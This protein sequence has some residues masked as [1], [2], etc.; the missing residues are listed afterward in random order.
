MGYGF[1]KILGK[2]IKN[3]CTKAKYDHVTRLCTDRDWYAKHK[4]DTNQLNGHSKTM[5]TVQWKQYKDNNGIAKLCRKESSILKAEVEKDN[6]IKNS[7]ASSPD[8]ITAEIL[9]PIEEL[10]NYIIHNLCSIVWRSEERFAT[11]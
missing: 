1:K 9:K 8:K 2:D 4:R 6:S 7:K 5:E 10:S 11:Y 3:A